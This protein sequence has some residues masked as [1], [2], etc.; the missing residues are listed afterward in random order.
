MRTCTA[1]ALFRRLRAFAVLPS[2]HDRGVGVEHDAYRFVAPA[3]RAR[4]SV[5]HEQLAPRGA[6]NPSAMIDLC[7]GASPGTSR[8]RLARRLQ[9]LEMW[10]LLEASFAAI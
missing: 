9:R 7:G 6:W 3:R 10:L 5:E 4:F 1:W 8:E 2:Q